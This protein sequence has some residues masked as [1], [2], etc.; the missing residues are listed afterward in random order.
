MM[1]RAQLQRAELRTLVA[2]AADGCAL[3]MKSIGSL[4][5]ACACAAQ[6]VDARRRAVVKVKHTSTPALRRSTVAVG[7]CQGQ[8]YPHPGRQ[9]SLEVRGK[10]TL[11]ESLDLYVQGELMEGDNQYFCEE[12]NRKVCQ[13]AVFW[14]QIHNFDHNQDYLRGRLQGAPGRH[15]GRVEGFV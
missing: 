8:P 5:R 2:A 10:R 7:C 12:A 9:V 1:L 13:R 4:R 14:R 3:Q 6:I 11:E 15:G